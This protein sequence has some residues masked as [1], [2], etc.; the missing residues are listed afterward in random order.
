METPSWAV[1][2]DARGLYYEGLVDN[3]NSLLDRHKICTVTSYDTRR[4]RKNQ[5]HVSANKDSESENTNPNTQV[6]KNNAKLIP[7]HFK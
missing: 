2:L 3:A 4:S 5:P 7:H 6:Q 1:G